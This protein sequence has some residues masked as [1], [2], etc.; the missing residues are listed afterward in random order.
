MMC[1]RNTTQIP[2]SQ[3]FFM[4]FFVLEE[5]NLIIKFTP[6][7]ICL[8]EALEENKKKF[9][10]IKKVY[11]E[12]E[13]NYQIIS[14][15][16]TNSD[17]ELCYDLMDIIEEWCIS[18]DEPQCKWFIQTKLGEKGISI[19]DFT[20]AILKISTIT[21]ELMNLC[22]QFELVILLSKLA[23]IDGIILKYITTA[24]SLY[25]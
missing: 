14:G 1:D 17:S 23:H 19:G 12:Y 3:I 2:N 25:V 7:A 13:E 10:E 24:Q 9:E 16:N 15:N 8:K 4:N 11:M 21:R 20:K 5:L 18:T 6:K 22:E